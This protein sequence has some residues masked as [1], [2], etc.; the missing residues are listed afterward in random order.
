[1]A[2]TT[3]NLYSLNK[4]VLQPQIPLSRRDS[5]QLQQQLCINLLFFMLYVR[6]LVRCSKLLL[7]E[8]EF[9]ESLMKQLTN[10]ECFP[11]KAVAHESIT[12]LFNDYRWVNG[13]LESSHQ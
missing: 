13:L 12:F 2:I 4:Q 1:M 9:L 7:R 5:I 8:F 11:F 3:K 10:K 6:T